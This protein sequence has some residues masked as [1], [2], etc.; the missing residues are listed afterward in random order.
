MKAES[1][2]NVVTQSA[3][4]SWRTIRRSPVMGIGIGIA[5]IILLIASLSPW[6]TLND[7]L[8]IQ[9]SQRLR[10]PSLEYPLGTDHM[11][12]CIISRLV[13]GT[14]Q[15]VG[16]SFC[17]SAVVILI[18]VP[19]GLLAGY[20]KGYLD[21]LLMRLA[22]AAGALPEF[23]LAI[24]VAGFL[25]PGLVNTL[26]AIACVKWIGYARLVRGITLSE[27]KKDYI[28]ASIVAGSGGWRIIRRHL[29]RQVA[30][31]LA[32]MAAADVGKTIL[33]ISALSYLG[34]GAQP[35]SPEWGAM[36]SDGRPYF[37]IAP[38]QMIYPGLCILIVVLA[39]NLISDGL[40]DLMD[41]RSR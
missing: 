16:L 2:T 33:L 9:M 32:I 24:A 15:T 26:F 30:S 22:D 21:A 19:L 6:L 17:A 36:L 18:G 13:A 37:Q 10:A 8:L 31:P 29:L 11:G 41:V 14:R 40:R 20:A 27:C 4:A 35:P 23:L 25:G 34:L 12:R 39:C 5:A 7:P 38:E 1:P 28:H 3:Y